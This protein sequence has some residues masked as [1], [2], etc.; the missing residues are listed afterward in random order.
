VSKATVSRLFLAGVIA[1]IS[2]VVLELAAVFAALGNGLVEIGGP[3]G[4]AVNGGSLTWTMLVVAVIG[5]LAITGGALTGLIAWIGA[6]LNTVQL[7][8]KT[9]FVVLLVLGLWSFGWL[10]MLVYVLFGPDGTRQAAPTGATVA[11]A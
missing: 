3:R 5:G 11:R 4:L 2:G 8:D 9:W 1:V 10:A 7:D 6:L